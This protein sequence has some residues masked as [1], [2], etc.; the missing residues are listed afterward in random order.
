[1]RVFHLIGAVTLLNSRRSLLRTCPP[2]EKMI[3]LLSMMKNW[4]CALDFQVKHILWQKLY[5]QKK[6]EILQTKSSE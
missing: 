3:R 4:N 5:Y 6:K 2:L 1:M